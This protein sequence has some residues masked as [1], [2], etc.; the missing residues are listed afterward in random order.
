MSEAQEAFKESNSQGM[1]T[2]RIT[3]SSQGYKEELYRF[4]GRR[5]DGKNLWYFL[6]WN[7]LTL[8]PMFVLLYVFVHRESHLGGLGQAISLCSPNMLPNTP[9]ELKISIRDKDKGRS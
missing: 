2:D 7:L 9:W 6:L 4:V 5:R 1:L 8:Y 3:I